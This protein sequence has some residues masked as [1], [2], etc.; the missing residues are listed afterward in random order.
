L[1]FLGFLFSY[2]WIGIELEFTLQMFKQSHDWVASSEAKFLD[3]EKTQTQMT[4]GR[5]L[6][7]DSK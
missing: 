3:G 6:N 7:T 2:D 4:V 1:V 5:K